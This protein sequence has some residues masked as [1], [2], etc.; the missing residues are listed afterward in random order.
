[1]LT[2]RLLERGRTSSRTDDTPEAI[3][4]RFRTFEL[5]SMPVV[6]ELRARGLVHQVDGAQA[7]DAVFAAACAAYDRAVS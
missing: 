2:E 5:Q 1:M 4:R 3:Q 7:E 6:E